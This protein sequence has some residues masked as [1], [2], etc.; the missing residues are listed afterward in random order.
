MSKKDLKYDDYKAYFTGKM[1]NK[2]RHAFE[3]KNMQNL[4]DSDA[5]DGISSHNNA[6]S[7]VS[8]MDSLHSKI[9]ERINI[10]K[11][12][13][14][15]LWMNYAATVFFVLGISGILYISYEY[16]SS[17]N[18]EQIVKLDIDNIKLLDSVD[19][20]QKLIYNDIDSIDDSLI[21]EKKEP[22][23]L[24]K[25]E[26]IILAEQT[27]EEIEDELV[28]EQEEEMISEIVDEEPSYN[29][30]TRVSTNTYLY[31]AQKSQKA[32]QAQKSSSANKAIM[33]LP[34]DMSTANVEDN[35]N[36]N[37]DNNIVAE[38][39]INLSREKNTDA[40]CFLVRDMYEFKQRVKDSLDYDLLKN[41]KGS[42]MLKFSFRVNID[43]ELDGFEF[44]KSPN[45]IFEKEIIRSVRSLGT[46]MPEVKN[47]VKLKS[48]IKVRMKI[49]N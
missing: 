15:P 45:N 42:L 29:Q 14:F 21:I 32:Q 16:S 27:E 43:G 46:W 36:A 34:K 13:I 18:S 6:R 26:I 40:Y 33:I 9:D 19:L 44:K 47:G 49:K 37:G 12:K 3:K 30:K 8:D 7:F 2:E 48:K 4:F 10:K 41:Y 23:L 28:I 20:S 24:Y 25:K 35:S 11:H 22:K 38:K 39:N 17:F 1:S 5:Y 31:T